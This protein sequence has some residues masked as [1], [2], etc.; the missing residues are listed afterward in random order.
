[1]LGY[2]RKEIGDEKIKV[3]ITRINDVEL[4]LSVDE[5]VE[6]Y[7]PSEDIK[8]DMPSLAKTPATECASGILKKDNGVVIV[9]SSELLISKAEQD[10]VDA[11][12]EK[13]N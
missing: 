12:L 13:Y 3:L 2:D 5:V 11:V 1:M 8:A 4:A 6:I 10:E 9:I 7:S